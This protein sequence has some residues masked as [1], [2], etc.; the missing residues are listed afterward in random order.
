LGQSRGT[1]VIHETE[2]S[3]ALRAIEIVTHHHFGK[4][5]I[6]PGIVTG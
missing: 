3:P 2:A 1:S 5:L 6:M 4:S